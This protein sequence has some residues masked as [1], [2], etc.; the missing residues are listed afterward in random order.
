MHYYKHVDADGNADG[1][2]S[3]SVPLATSDVQ[4]E[5]TKDE[6]N[7]YLADHPEPEPGE[8]TISDA[9]NALSVLGYTE[10]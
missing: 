7:Q 10:E 6:F 1:V 9:L 5:I 2:V 4:I 8:S 3:C